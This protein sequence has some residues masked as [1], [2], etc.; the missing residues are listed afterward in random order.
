[1]ADP[2]HDWR[3]TAVL[4]GQTVIYGAPVGSSISMV[5]AEVIGFTRSGRVNVRPIRRAYGRW[6]SKD[7]VHVGPDRLT[8]IDRLPPYQEVAPS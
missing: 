4:I 7:V 1:M 5:E 6:Q 8:V 2:V 3:G